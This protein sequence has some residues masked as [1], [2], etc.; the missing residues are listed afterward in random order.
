MLI[1]RPQHRVK[2]YDFSLTDE[3]RKEIRK[4]KKNLSPIR[5]KFDKIIQDA[6]IRKM[7]QRLGDP[8]TRCENRQRVKRWV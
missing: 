2:C 8:C 1:E 6:E 7:R 3:E 4:K 5:K